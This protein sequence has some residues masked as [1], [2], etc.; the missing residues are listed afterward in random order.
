MRLGR[1]HVRRPRIMG[2]ASRATAVGAAAR[3]GAS[4]SEL[5]TFGSG[6]RP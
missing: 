5:G 6:G 2:I 3:R 1:G 4:V